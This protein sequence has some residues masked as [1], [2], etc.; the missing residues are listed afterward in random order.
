MRQVPMVGTFVVLACLEV[1]HTVVL[2]AFVQDLS[3][4][5]RCA[6]LTQDS[7]MHIHFLQFHLGAIW[8]TSS[9]GSSSPLIRVVTLRK[10]HLS[11]SLCR[12]SL[13][14][15]ASSILLQ[16]SLWPPVSFG[17]APLVLSFY[18]DFV[19]VAFC[20]AG[21]SVYL[22]RCRSFQALV[23]DL[24]PSLHLLPPLPF[25]PGSHKNCRSTHLLALATHASCHPWK[26]LLFYC[27]D[28]P[29]R[30]VLDTI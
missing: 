15:L 8:V 16:C 28:H 27:S 3:L 26:W 10:S 1:V 11:R 21:L 17:G 6:Y 7:L 4:F 18:F 23:L 29:R 30:S 20:C 2:V 13:P 14:L 5:G 25:L 9:V 24:V 12:A 19:P 22:G